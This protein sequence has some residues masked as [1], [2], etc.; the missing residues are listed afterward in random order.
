MGTVLGVDDDRFSLRIM[1]VRREFDFM[2]VFSGKLEYGFVFCVCRSVD[3][4]ALRDLYYGPDN[5]GRC[6]FAH[7]LILRYH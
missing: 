4:V 7:L 2:L 3:G 6:T 1:F 5:L